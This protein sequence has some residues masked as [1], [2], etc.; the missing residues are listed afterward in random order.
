[1]LNLAVGIMMFVSS[2]APT[3]ATNT[4]TSSAPISTSTPKVVS[5]A[6]VETELNKTT[7][8]LVRE[9]F[10]DIPIMVDI[11]K[12]ESQF[13]QFNKDG[14]VH[15]GRINPADVG[16]FQVNESYH[17]K[18]SKKLGLDIYSV[19]GNLKYARHLYEN[20]GVDPWSA[21]SPCWGKR[22]VVARK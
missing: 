7:E 20:E 2:V 1:M 9:E 17:L 12:C 5:V 6:K 15:R 22:I 13:T 11:A 10:S 16:T 18:E 3:Q 4:S 21:S 14:S 8:D 19:E